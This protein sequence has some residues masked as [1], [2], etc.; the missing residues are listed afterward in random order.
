MAITFDAPSTN[1][2]TASRLTEEPRVVYPIQ[3]NRTAIFY[4]HDFV[5]NQA[6]YSTTAL[7]TVMASTTLTSGI[8]SSDTTLPVA[9]TAGFASNGKVKIGS[10]TIPYTGRTST[11]FTGATVT[12]THSS[13]AAVSSVAYLGRGNS[14]AKPVGRDDRVDK[15][16]RDHP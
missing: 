3:Q 16:I 6:N 14:P 15:K 2:A 4:E 7:D 8:N 12:A 9:S 10:E 5:I 1:W 13:S 11:S